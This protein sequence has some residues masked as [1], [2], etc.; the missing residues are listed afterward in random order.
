VTFTNIAPIDDGAASLRW[1]AAG[2]RRVRCDGAEGVYHG[3]Q[4]PDDA[5]GWLASVENPS[6]VTPTAARQAELDAAKTARAAEV[7]KAEHNRTRLETLGRRAARYAR[8]GLA[9]DD[10]LP[11]VTNGAAKRSAHELMARTALS[12]VGLLSDDT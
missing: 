1:Q 4:L 5:G 9:T 10:L 3:W 11:G 8:D 7:A 6:L 2:A 12:I